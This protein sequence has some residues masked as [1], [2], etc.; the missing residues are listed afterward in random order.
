VTATAAP[1]PAAEPDL[2]PV[3]AILAGYPKAE[4][5]LIQVLQ[6]VNRTYN[7]LPCHALELVA[8]QLGV[9]LARVFSVATFYKAFS[10]KPRGKVIIRICTGTACHI[11]GA[12]LL[13]DEFVRHLHV[14]AGETTPDMAFTLETVNCVGACAMAPVV[15]AGPRHHGGMSP[16]DVPDVI[17]GKSNDD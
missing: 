2:A 15:I 3:E 4:T 9:P 5:S 12:P 10:I 1:K 7:Y 6:D 11:R 14:Q 8:R 17:Q 16:A 13:V